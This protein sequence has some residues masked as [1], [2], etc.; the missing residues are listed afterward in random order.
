MNN[1]TPKPCGF[2]LL[3]IRAVRRIV[4]SPL[5]PYVFQAVILAVLVALAILGWGQFAPDGVPAKQFAQTNLVT[6]VIWGLWWPAM[7]WVIVI[8][9]RA[10]CAICPLELVSN[11]AE[12]MGRRIGISQYVL[13]HWLRSGFLIVGFYAVIQ[14]LIAG[15]ELH[16]VPAHTSVF[17]WALVATAG[18]TGL[19]FKHR[20]FCR[21]FCPVGLLF[22]TYARGAML[23]VRSCGSAA[24]DSCQGKD[25]RQ[26]ERR[27]R[28][29]ARSCPSLLDPVTLNS[30][31]DCLVCLQCAKACP[32]SNIGLFV[33]RPFPAED[34]REAMASWP[35]LL[36]LIVL[37][38]YVGYEL[39]SEWKEAQA[40]FL[41]VPETVA[42][43]L[44]LSRAVGW[45]RGLW[46]VVVFPIT[47][48]TILGIPV[49]L[50]RGA[51]SL[52]EAWRRLAVPM[53]VILAAG[54]LAKG[55]AK[56]AQ[57]AGYSAL[58]WADPSGVTTAQAI[59]AGG[60]RPGAL[61]SRSPPS[62]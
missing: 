7:V 58:A 43:W 2:N 29:D 45:V 14:M 32:S 3:R 41:W 54:H 48:W 20:A 22:A 17:L 4:L 16:R 25:C 23:A 28:L 44:G 47:L 46:A 50:L 24:C 31:A 59:V 49:V 37:S 18:L 12:R 30:N 9:G 56:F 62:T 1:S 34:D 39:C 57:W 42:A 38:G 13:G 33:R 8:F 36:F 6:L 40:A 60:A 51:G 11:F 35:V 21:G 61:W 10:W 26:P 5:F 15:V 52:G 19:F 55:V 27:D 53:T